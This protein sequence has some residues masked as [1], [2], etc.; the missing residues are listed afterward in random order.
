[1][2]LN[3]LFDLKIVY[4]GLAL[5]VSGSLLYIIKS[6]PLK[7]WR[8]IV[9]R[10]SFSVEIPDNDDAFEWL[11]HWFSEYKFIGGIK[12]FSL[13]TKINN[14]KIKL[15]LSPAPGIHYFFYKK[16]LVKINKYRKEFESMG[17]GSK[18]FYENIH[19]TVY[20]FKK[21]IIEDIIHEAN[22][23]NKDH[24]YGVYILRQNSWGGWSYPKFYPARRYDSIIL[25]DE[26]DQKILGD[27][28][29]FL[30]SHEWYEKRGIPYRRGI[31]L[32]GPPG[33]GKTSI[34]KGLAAHLKLQIA[35]ISFN[36]KD[37][38]D[39][40]LIQL[41]SSLPANTILLLE[42]IDRIFDVSQ[43]NEAR[44]VNVTFSGLLNAIDGVLTPQNL[45]IIMTA[46]H[47]DKL[48]EALIRPGRIDKRFYVGDATK[49]QARRFFEHFYGFASLAEEFAERYN[50]EVSMSVLQ[51]HFLE[52]KYNPKEAIATW[53]Q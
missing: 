48:D 43:N 38:N 26:L 19:I 35:T 9:K 46:N 44:K 33:N 2:Q 14:N 6:V 39:D 22:N 12:S 34:V 36:T 25:N 51:E 7:I 17:L 11:T 49:D 15:M 47:F 52:H 37:F 16:R 50:R 3:E 21:E 32:H 1:M 27:V 23:F 31:A 4:S 18:P 10:S 20:S 24:A 8:F 5:M 30:G 40:G 41:V 42:D 13:Y 53:N 28:Q 45:I 29:E